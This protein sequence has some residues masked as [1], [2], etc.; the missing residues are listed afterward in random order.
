LAAEMGGL[1][2]MG[3]G[4]NGIVVGVGWGTGLMVEEKIEGEGFRSVEVMVL[5]AGAGRTGFVSSD[6]MEGEGLS[7]SGCGGVDL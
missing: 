4:L 1:D 3:A 2:W 7:W 6:K 5:G